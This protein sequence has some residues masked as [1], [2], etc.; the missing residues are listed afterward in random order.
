MEK[1]FYDLLLTIEKEESFVDFIT[2]KGLETKKFWDMLYEAIEKGFVIENSKKF[3]LSI[4]GVEA[5]KNRPSKK[6]FFDDGRNKSKIKYD[7]NDIYLPKVSVK[8]QGDKS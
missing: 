4:L 1:I 6:E 5:L 7:T 8:L 2:N 3:A